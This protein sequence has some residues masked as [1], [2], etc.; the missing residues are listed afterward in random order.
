MAELAI[1]LQPDRAVLATLDAHGIADMR[2]IERLHLHDTDACVAQLLAAVQ[3]LADRA[4]V[5][6]V[7]VDVAVATPDG[8]RIAERLAGACGL[9]G[10]AHPRGICVTWAEA[11][12][13]AAKDL[14]SFVLFSLGD[15]LDGGV[16]IDRRP[17]LRPLDLAH[18]RVE[19]LGPLCPCGLRGCLQ[20]Y[21]STEALDAWATVLQVPRNQP[22][23]AGRDAGLHDELAWRAAAGERQVLA[24]LDEATRAIGI[25]LAGLLQAFDVRTVVLMTQARAGAQALLPLLSAALSLHAGREVL[26]LPAQLGRDAALLGAGLLP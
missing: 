23:Q 26:V 7:R 1:D 4:P 25:A 11:K 13:G 14:Q 16:V 6:I 15:T 18:L 5:P 19:P 24:L 10:T 20:R 2:R 22:A 12:W 17:W 3:V 8:R 9:P 21:V